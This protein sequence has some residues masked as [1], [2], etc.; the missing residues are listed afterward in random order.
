[1]NTDTCAHEH[2]HKEGERNSTVKVRLGLRLA[3]NT[4]THGHRSALAMNI[5][6]AHSKLLKTK[7][8]ANSWY[9]KS[10]CHSLLFHLDYKLTYSMGHLVLS[11]KILLLLTTTGHSLGWAEWNYSARRGSGYN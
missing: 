9:H 8:K 1:M 2:T 4:Q 10:I 11:S 3:I 6:C 5:E 7:Q